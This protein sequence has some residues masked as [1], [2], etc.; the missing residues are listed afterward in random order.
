MNIHDLVTRYVAFRRALGERCKTNEGILRA[1]CPGRRVAP[2]APRETRW[3]MIKKEVDL[4]VLRKEVGRALLRRRPRRT[5]EEV[6][7][8]VLKRHGLYSPASVA[9]FIANERR[10]VK[11]VYEAFQRSLEKPVLA[12]ENRPGA[13]GMRVVRKSTPLS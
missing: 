2:E 6:V 11:E 4:A 7:R 9:G 13:R 8:V 3:S 1:F 12:R 5:I 10:L